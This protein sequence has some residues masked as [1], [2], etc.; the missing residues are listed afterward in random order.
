VT[1]RCV[2][3]GILDIHA[4]DG[5]SDTLALAMLCALIG[6]SLWVNSATRL[7]M[8]VSTTHS[9]GEL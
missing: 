3:A 8:P 6:S 1:E 4:F 2:R 7:G 5:Q 9:I